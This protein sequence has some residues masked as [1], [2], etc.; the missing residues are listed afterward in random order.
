[1][2]LSG[3]RVSIHSDG[4]ELKEYSVEVSPDGKKATCWVPSQSGKNFEVKYQIGDSSVIKQKAKLVDVLMDGYWM[5]GY[6]L[7]PQDTKGTARGVQT[8][9]NKMRPFKFADIQITD[10]DTVPGGTRVNSSD[11]GTICVQVF[12]AESWRRLDDNLP[13]TYEIQDHP[14]ATMDERAKKALEHCVSLGDE[15]PAKLSNRNY[16]TVCDSEKPDLVFDFRYRSTPMLQALD[17]I[18]PPKS[19]APLVIDLEDED[20]LP[21]PKRRK[22]AHDGDLV[23]SMQTELD[24]LRRRVDELEGERAGPSGVKKE[25]IKHDPDDIIDLT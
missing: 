4:E 20:A 13:N 7:L 2:E 14:P 3:F 12:L 8:S 15:Q 24:R 23:Q 5:Q 19:E 6:V 22:A 9:D 11:I 17:I 1:M 18:P 25:V 21:P 10:E 16:S